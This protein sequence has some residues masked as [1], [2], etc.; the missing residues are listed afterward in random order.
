MDGWLVG[1]RPLRDVSARSRAI[2]TRQPVTS[3]TG[4]SK[5]RAPP[6]LVRGRRGKKKRAD[7]ARRSGATGDCQAGDGKSRAG[8]LAEQ[9]GY[10]PRN[11]VPYLQLSKLCWH[12]Q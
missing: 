11:G 3:A 6:G 7:H 1:L 8:G 12:G 4:S 5:T 9:A 2:S 10:L